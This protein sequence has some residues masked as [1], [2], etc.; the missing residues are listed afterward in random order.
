VNARLM[1]RRTPASIVHDPLRVGA[2]V[3]KVIGWKM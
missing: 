1:L 2:L 3:N